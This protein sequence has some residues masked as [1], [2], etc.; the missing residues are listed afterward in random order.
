[1]SFYAT[2]ETQSPSADHCEECQVERPCDH[3]ANNMPI[4]MEREGAYWVLR[5]DMIETR[6]ATKAEAIEWRD[7][8]AAELAS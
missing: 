6:F 4:T 3:D 5:V 1:M 8:F 2:E 7:I